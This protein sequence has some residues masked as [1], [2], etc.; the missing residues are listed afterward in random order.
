MLRAAVSTFP[1]SSRALR[2]HVDSYYKHEV[3]SSAKGN[4]VT[5]AINVEKDEASRFQ[6]LYTV[7]ETGTFVASQKRPEIEVANQNG[8]FHMQRPNMKNDPHFDKR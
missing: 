4:Y 6:R 5:K 1:I 2:Y 8:P 7:P 3:K